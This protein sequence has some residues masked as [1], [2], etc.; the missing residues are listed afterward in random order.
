M[1]KARLDADGTAKPKTRIV[2]HPNRDHCVGPGMK[3]NRPEFEA[4]DGTRIP[5]GSRYRLV[6]V[7]METQI[8]S[9]IDGA[10]KSVELPEV[11]RLDELFEEIR[12]IEDVLDHK[13]PVGF[14]Y[15]GVSPQHRSLDVKPRPELAEMLDGMMLDDLPFSYK[16]IIRKSGTALITAEYTQILGSRWLAIVDAAQVLEIIG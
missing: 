2:H 7:T 12:P 16:I 15:C 14:S 8:Q 11:R 9:E 13:R 1:A 6:E 5:L 10:S 3:L 4:E